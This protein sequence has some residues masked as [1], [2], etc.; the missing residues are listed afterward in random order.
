MKGY[1]FHQRLA[2]HV[3][4]L[5]W[6]MRSMPEPSIADRGL[7][8]LIWACC[9]ESEKNGDD[10]LNVCIHSRPAPGPRALAP[11]GIKKL[12]AGEDEQNTRRRGGDMRLD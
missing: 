2:C 8:R 4:N 10:A 5:S 3:S 6:I 7:R 9:R 1:E 12:A 11:D